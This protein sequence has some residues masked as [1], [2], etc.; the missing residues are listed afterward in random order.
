MQSV[1]NI[2]FTD[3]SIK[4]Q[5]TG[6]ISENL[7]DSDIES[8]TLSVLLLN[9]LQNAFANKGNGLSLKSSTLRGQM[10]SHRYIKKREFTVWGSQLA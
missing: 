4:M 3:E 9:A 7:T 10:G 8:V 5:I 6:S 2:L 1:K